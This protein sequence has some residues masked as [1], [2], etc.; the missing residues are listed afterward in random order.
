MLIGNKQ[1]WSWV[2]CHRRH[3]DAT[4]IGTVGVILQ[5]RRLTFTIEPV[6]LCDMTRDFFDPTP[7]TQNV[8]LIDSA[9]LQKAQRMI[10]GCEACSETTEMPFDY[11]LDRLTD[12]DPSVTDY[13][14]EMLL[15]WAGDR[16]LTG[17]FCELEELT[18]DALNRVA[19]FDGDSAG[20]CVSS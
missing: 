17:R 19:L 8:V 3:I 2:A 20:P 6:I 12:S 1:G 10:S 14:L 4:A 7:E 15:C 11:I 9:T 16:V 18:Q 5:S 13:V